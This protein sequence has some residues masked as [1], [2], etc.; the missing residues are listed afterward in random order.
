MCYSIEEKHLSYTDVVN[1][2]HDTERIKDTN[3]LRM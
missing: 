2:V 1:L 3:Q